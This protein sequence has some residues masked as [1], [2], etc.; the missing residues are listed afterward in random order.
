MV[1]NAAVQVHRQ[2]K[3]VTRYHVNKPSSSA[4]LQLIVVIEATMSLPKEM[5]A[6]TFSVTGEA[7]VNTIPL[8]PLRPTHML[9]KIHS[10]A[11]NPTDAKCIYWGKPAKPF[12]IVGC[13]YAGT[14]VSIGSE[15][16][17]SFKTGDQVFGV[18]HGSNKSEAYDGVFAEYAVVKGDVTMHAPKNLA[19]DDLCT[20]PLCAITAGQGLFQPNKGLGLSLPEQGKGNGEW[21]LIYGGSTTSGCLGI[22]FAKLAGY[23]VIV[24]CSPRNNDLVKSRGAD[25]AFDYNDPEWPSK[26]RKFT[27]NKL[28]YVWDTICE[29]KACCDA[30]SSDDEGCRYS[31]ILFVDDDFPR[32]GVETSVTLM[33]TMFGEDFDK[34][35]EEWPASHEDWTFAKMWMELTEKLVS[36][37]KVVPHPK[38]AEE[39][40]L[41]GILKGI[42]ELKEERVRGEK[43]VYRIEDS[44]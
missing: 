29:P 42:E 4:H 9:V 10:V 6:V 22:Q 25:K 37:G 1:F 15:V 5:K 18:V 44:V 28:K 38:R 17:K 19:L 26:V 16:T 33:Y 34:Y 21:L 27:D 11:L 43:L 35:G 7:A 39:G 30:L 24:T 41:Q 40:G 36:E 20:I 14:V 13:D 3:K 23:K 32:K 8:P 12:S 2:E 31:T